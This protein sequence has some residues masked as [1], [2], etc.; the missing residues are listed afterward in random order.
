[1]NKYIEASR[2]GEW[3]DEARPLREE[4]TC[5]RCMRVYNIKTAP[6]TRSSS[7]PGFYTK[8]PQC[9]HCKCRLYLS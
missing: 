3:V 8:C 9:P 6:R 4:V 7:C 1:M 5:I 2:S